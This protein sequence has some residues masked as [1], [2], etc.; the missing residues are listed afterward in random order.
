[1]DIKDENE[2]EQWRTA[3]GKELQ[4][5]ILAAEQ[6][7]ERVKP[8]GNQDSL[9][10]DMD[11]VIERGRHVFRKSASTSDSCFDGKRQGSSSLRWHA[12]AWRYRNSVFPFE[13]RNHV[14]DCNFGQ[15]LVC[16]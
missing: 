13:I 16:Q 1:M 5:L 11:R 12:V 8:R 10:E 14:E 15:R 4:E 7:I 9:W 6:I 2:R 3:F